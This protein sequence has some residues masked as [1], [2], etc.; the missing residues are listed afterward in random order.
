MN[1][2]EDIAIKAVN[3]AI[4]DNVN[5][6]ILNSF[7]FNTG[8]FA[9]TDFMINSIINSIDTV[10]K[11]IDVAEFNPVLEAIVIPDNKNAKPAINNPAP[12]QSKSDEIFVELEFLGNN[13]IDNTPDI[14]E[15]NENNINKA[16]QSIKPAINPVSYTHLTLPTKRIV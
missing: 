3:V 6:G 1:G 2:T 15:R 9:R 14:K 13:I 5:T 7:I 8:W 4:T 10:N 16:R 12:A 11:V